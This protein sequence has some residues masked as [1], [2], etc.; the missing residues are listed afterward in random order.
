MPRAKKKEAEPSFEKD[1]EALEAVVAALEEGGLSLD[2]SLK[3]FEQGIALSRRCEGALSQAEK[4]IEILMKNADGEVEAKNFGDEDDG[5]GGD[6][7]PA[8]AYETDEEE[9]EDEELLF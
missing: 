7:P 3:Q 1:L 6:E 8:E 5:G 4:K 9:D 2:E